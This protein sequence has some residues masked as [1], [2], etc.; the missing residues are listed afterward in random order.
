[1]T[2]IP[3]ISINDKEQAVLTTSTGFNRL[4]EGYRIDLLAVS[5]RLMVDEQRNIIRRSI[6]NAS[7]DQD[8]GPAN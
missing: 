6:L 8:D 2:D 3:K 7:V 1:M 5:I 4:D